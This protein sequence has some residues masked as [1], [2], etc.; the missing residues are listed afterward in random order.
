[1]H[2]FR[3]WIG[4]LYRRHDDR[5]VQLQVFQRLPETA[6]RLGCRRKFDLD[7]NALAPRVGDESGATSVA[8]RGVS[9][10]QQ[11]APSLAIGID[12]GAQSREQIR[13]ALHLVDDDKTPSLLGQKQLGPG[14][15]R[16]VGS[17]L[18]KNHHCKLITQ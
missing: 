6:C 18:Q 5:P 13:Q 8:S 9:S 3:Q 4:A 16:A 17:A 14:Q 15:G 11:K 7:A 2:G 10:T 12:L 1:L